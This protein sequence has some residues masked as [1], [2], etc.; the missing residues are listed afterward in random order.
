MGLVVQDPAYHD[1]FRFPRKKM[2]IVGLSF[3]LLVPLV[4]ADPTCKTVVTKWTLWTSPGPGLAA[5]IDVPV[6]EELDGWEV[7]VKFNKNFSKINFFNGLSEAKSGKEFRVVN[8]AWSGVKHPGGHIK[9]SLLGD[10]NQD[11]EEAIQVERVT[12]QG[13]D[14]VGECPE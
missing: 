3:F 8:E 2:A 11:G 9:F 12:L 1:Y 6:E 13:K 10:Y 4:F 5:T 14:V 7:K